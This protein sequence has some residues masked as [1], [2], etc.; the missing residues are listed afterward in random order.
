MLCSDTGHSGIGLLLLIVIIVLKP[1]YLREPLCL[2]LPFFEQLK[3]LLA[4]LL[5]TL[6]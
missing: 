6:S 2:Y 1:K 4:I 5:E 3:K